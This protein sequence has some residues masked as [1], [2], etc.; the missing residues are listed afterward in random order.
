MANN[1]EQSTALGD[2]AA[3]QLAIATRTVPQ[4]GTITPRWL[5]H[6]MQWVPVEAGI[7]RVNRVKDASSVTV[8]CSGRDERELPQT[9]VDYIENPRE[10]LLSAVNTVLD[11]H[12]RI[13]DLYSSPHDQVKEQL[14]LTI[15]TIKENQESELIN[16]PDYGLLAQVTETLRFT[17]WIYIAP[18]RSPLAIAKAVATA[19]GAQVVAADGAAIPSEAI[20]HGARRE[21][22]DAT[23]VWFPSALSVVADADL[24][25]GIVAQR[26]R[27]RVTDAPDAELHA[28][29]RLL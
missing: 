29:V 11:V 21:S 8:D 12:T 23:V 13:S 20:P 4:M 6:L 15:E 14:R 10:Y 27:E 18:P 2:I 24:A 16:N 3:R 19:L 26:Y 17:T 1:H 5:T 28:V 9:F 22:S 25:A 7:Y